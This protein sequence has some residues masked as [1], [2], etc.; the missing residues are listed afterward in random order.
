MY[1]LVSFNR[2]VRYREEVM[3]SASRCEDLICVLA[4]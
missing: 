4:I 1:N 2:E 3:S